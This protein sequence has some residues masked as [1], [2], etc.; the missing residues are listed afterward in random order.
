MFIAAKDIKFTAAWRKIKKKGGRGALFDPTL[1]VLNHPGKFGPR[2]AHETGTGIWHLSHLACAARYDDDFFDFWHL[3][4]GNS[5]CLTSLKFGMEQA[6]GKALLYL[7][8]WPLSCVRLRRSNLAKSA[9]SAKSTSRLSWL[10]PVC[11]QLFFKETNRT[12]VGEVFSFNLR[13]LTTWSAVFSRRRE[14]LRKTQR[15]WAAPGGRTNESLTSGC[16]RI[17]GLRQT[18]E[19]TVVK[20]ARKDFLVL[21]WIAGGEHLLF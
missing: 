21:G 1:P 19:K 9:L 7:F 15:V 5:F 17:P 18:P 8:E 10:L 6:R 2:I 20:A 4:F 16:C 12:F 11:F 14:D 13:P 3:F